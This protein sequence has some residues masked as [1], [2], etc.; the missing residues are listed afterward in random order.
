MLS[1]LAAFSS[2]TEQMVQAAANNGKTRLS[3]LLFFH[4][5]DDISVGPASYFLFLRSLRV[6]SN[7]DDT[8]EIR[9]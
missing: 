6:R 9:I 3:S 4:N 1:F 8:R 5:N 2:T 7:L